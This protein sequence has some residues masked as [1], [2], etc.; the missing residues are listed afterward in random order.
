MLHDLEALRRLW[1]GRSE[2]DTTIPARKASGIETRPGFLRGKGAE[3]WPN[4]ATWIVG[5]R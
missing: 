2:R 3:S 5:E 4:T 1:L